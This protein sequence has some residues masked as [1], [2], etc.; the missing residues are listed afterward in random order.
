M[1]ILL[2]PI[3]YAENGKHIAWSEKNIW[4]WMEKKELMMSLLLLLCYCSKVLVRHPPP[5]SHHTFDDKTRSTNW[6]EI[7][8]IFR[9]LSLSLLVVVVGFCHRRFRNWKKAKFSI[10]DAALASIV[11][12]ESGR[13]TTVCVCV[14]GVRRSW[15]Q[16]CVNP[17]SFY[18][19][20]SAI[21][22]FFLLPRQRRENHYSPF[23][24]TAHATLAR[25]DIHWASL[26]LVS[27]V[28]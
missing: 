7:L 1:F 19:F 17:I 15:S 6:K 21:P 9:W 25:D 18:D 5:Q 16:Q 23:S 2:I 12:R 8:S 26:E 20:I 10:V 14:C 28:S 27:R 22:S 24:Q 4:G 3:Q 13:K 11:S